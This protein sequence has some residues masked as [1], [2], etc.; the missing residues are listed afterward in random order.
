MGVELAATD[1]THP[2]LSSSRDANSYTL[3]KIGV[4]HFVVK[5]MPETGKYHVAS[6][7]ISSG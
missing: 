1:G 3:G 4:H 7:T 2:S 6:P 5:V